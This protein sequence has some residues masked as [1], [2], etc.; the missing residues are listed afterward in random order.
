[1]LIHE[2]LRCYDINSLL[3]IAYSR[4]LA[5]YFQPYNYVLLIVAFFHDRVISH[6]LFYVAGNSLVD[7]Y[8]HDLMQAL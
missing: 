6:T 1:V 3:Q 5:T 4:P 2:S 8:I 7:V